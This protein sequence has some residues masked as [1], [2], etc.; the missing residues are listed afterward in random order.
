MNLLENPFYVL[1]ASTIDGR[2]RLI[3]LA[4]EILLKGDSE[5]GTEAR[6]ALTNPRK[7]LAAEVAWLPG[8]KKDIKKELMQLIVMKRGIKNIR[9]KWKIP[10]LSFANVIASILSKENSYEEGKY[11]AKLLI[12][13]FD[14]ID[15]KEIQLIVNQDRLQAGF[16]EVDGIAEFEKEVEERRKYFSSRLSEFFNSLDINLYGSTLI[17]LMEEKL[18]KDDSEPILI[19]DLVNSYEVN[20][21]QIL[22][23]EAEKIG[24]IINQANKHL[25]KSSDE[26]ELKEILNPLINGIKTW[27]KIASPIQLS[28]KNRG[29]DDIQSN[30]LALEVR[31]LAANLLNLNKPRMARSLLEYLNNI[32]AEVP[33]IYE[34]TKNDL[35][36]IKKN[37]LIK[38]TFTLL[39]IAAFPFALIF[40]GVLIDYIG[41]KPL[42]V[43][44]HQNIFIKEYELY[45]NKSRYQFQIPPISRNTSYTDSEIRW[46]IREKITLDKLDNIVKTKPEKNN[47]RI[48]DS[49]YQIRC[50]ASTS[51]KTVVDQIASQIES[52]VDSINKYTETRLEFIRSNR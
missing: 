9:N 26:D 22:N 31:A 29:I 20:S 36:T 21:K 32:F 16:R 44:S 17:V 30:N 39:I 37:N 15:I 46:C 1:E 28:K 2:V 34:L 43:T 25:E 11:L 35:T 23:D 50:K 52:E 8:V 47:Y 33:Y 3:E 51:T 6:L 45:P 19:S 24:Q 12:L 7:R 5:I 4:E 27:H 49:S 41:K 14:K 10:A 38:I 18:T 13:A 42:V 40:I 48:L